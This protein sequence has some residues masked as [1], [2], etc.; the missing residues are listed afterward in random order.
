LNVSVAVELVPCTRRQMKLTTAGCVRLFNSVAEEKPKP[1]EARSA[2]IACPAG[3]VR[4]G[5]RP[6]Q[7]AEG[8]EAWR[9]CC[10]RC[11]AAGRR[12]I[13]GSLCVSCYN[14]DRE[15]AVGRDRKGHRPRLADQIHAARI[16]VIRDGTATPTHFNRVLNAA[17]ALVATAKSATG[18]LLFGWP[19]AELAEA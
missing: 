7:A 17:E 8:V 4:N 1:W 16:V 13:A 5:R 15:A 18:P 2:C 3:A 14:R 10:T 12:M 19:P 9:L 11:Q 6:N